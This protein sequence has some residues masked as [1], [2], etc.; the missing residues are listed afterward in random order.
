MYKLK[1]LPEDF[2][3]K[4]IFS[5]KLYDK[6]EYVYVLLTKKNYNTLDAIKAISK[7]LNI[8]MKS[9]GF[10][11]SKD[12]NAVTTQ[13]ISIRTSEAKQK[14]LEKIALND[15]SIEVLGQS[16]KPVSL[17]DHEGNEFIITVRN[18]DSIP[19]I[20]PKFINYFGEQ[21]F[22]KNNIEIG[23]AMLKREWKKAVELIDD[24]NVKDYFE[25]NPTDPIGAIKILP[26]KLISMYIHAY[27]SDIW[28]KVA[29]QVDCDE[30]STPGF[31]IEETDEK[32]DSLTQ[33]FLEKDGIDERA[34]IIRE[35]Q[36]I[37]SEGKVRKRIAKAENLKIVSESEDELNKG[38][39]KIIIQFSLG[40][41]SYATEFV[42]QSFT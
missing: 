17:G 38:K 4:E 26:G 21:R 5:P 29:G 19:N 42:K 3:V 40:K 25:K 32:A 12:R 34:F 23:K 36:G 35:I 27:Q 30:F 28:N 20:N 11:G 41:G 31:G 24:K 22:G 1:Q 8:V 37:N 13:V 33:E 2:I 15:I 9:F 39:K 18:I 14:L 10:A 6:G 16:D 7:K